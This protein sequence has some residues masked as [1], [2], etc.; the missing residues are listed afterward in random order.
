MKKKYNTVRRLLPDFNEDDEEIADLQEEKDALKRKFCDKCGKE[1]HGEQAYKETFEEMA[2]DEFITM[3]SIAE[4]YGGV[5]SLSHTCGRCLKDQPSM[6]CSP[7][8]QH[9]LCDKKNCS[10]KCHESQ[11][12]G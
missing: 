12:E 10:C 1:L 7:S 4:D 6:W 3:M 8:E 11:K 2:D 9:E 5:G